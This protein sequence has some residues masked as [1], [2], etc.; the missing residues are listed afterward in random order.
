MLNPAELSALVERLERASQTLEAGGCLTQA[1]A[2]RYYLVYVY[3]VQAAEKHGVAFRRGAQ[4]DDD[5]TVSHRS[6]PNVVQAL[7]TGQNS[8]PVIG[9]GPGITRAGRLSDRD[10][11]VYTNVLQKDRIYA[12]YG[13][14]E[15][16]E[17]YDRK[18]FDERMGYAERLVE[19]LRTLL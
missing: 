7:Y 17:P 8:G 3:A 6:L 19:D 11:F 1:L 14:S 2:R 5:R 15:V 13:Y 9:A 4:T 12:D 18:T 10:A 16:P